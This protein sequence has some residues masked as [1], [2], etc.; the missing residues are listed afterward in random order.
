MLTGNRM[1]ARINHKSFLSHARK[2]RRLWAMAQSMTLMTSP[3]DALEG[4]SLQKSVHIM[5][6]R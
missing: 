1:I 4:I 2:S 5:L 6:D 3:L